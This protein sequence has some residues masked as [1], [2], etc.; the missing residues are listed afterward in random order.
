MSKNDLPFAYTEVVRLM[1]QNLTKKQIIREPVKIAMN[2]F[3]YGILVKICK[4]M[5]DKSYVAI[6]IDLFNEVSDIYG[7]LES[8]VSEREALLSRLD[9]IKTD[10]ILMESDIRKKCKEDDFL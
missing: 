5:D 2:E 3:L 8:I 4:K 6:D 1:R 9:S 10:I 7:E